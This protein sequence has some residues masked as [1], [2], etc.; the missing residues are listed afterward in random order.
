MTVL[1]SEIDVHQDYTVSGA[2]P[3]QS[4]RAHRKNSGS[5]ALGKLT[6]RARHRLHGW[7]AFF[8]VLP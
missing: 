6:A 4:L 3:A 7:A 5:Q 1:P 2:T 8:K